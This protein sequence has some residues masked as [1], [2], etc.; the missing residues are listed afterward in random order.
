MISLEHLGK[1]P[2]KPDHVVYVLALVLLFGLPLQALNVNR[3]Q[4]V[5]KLVWL[6]VAHARCERDPFDSLLGAFALLLDKADCL[7]ELLL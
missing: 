1:K 7:F 2:E 6:H 5:L 4:E 3:N